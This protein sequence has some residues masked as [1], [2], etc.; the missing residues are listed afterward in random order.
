MLNVQ[1]AEEKKQS[2]RRKRD[3]RKK[4]IGEEIRKKTGEINKI[5][6]P[7]PTHGRPEEILHY[8]L[9]RSKCVDYYLLLS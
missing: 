2:E 6:A 4:V 5:K 9:N 1:S 7:Q 8:I 3:G